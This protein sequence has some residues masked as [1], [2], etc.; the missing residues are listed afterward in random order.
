MIR[1]FLVLTVLASCGGAATTTPLDPVDPGSPTPPAPRVKFDPVPQEIEAS[2]P[3]V[4]LPAVPAFDLPEAEPGFRSVKELRVAGRKLLGT[5]VKVKG[6]VAWVYNCADA[7]VAGGVPAATVKQTIDADPT[8]CERPNF[9]LAADQGD[10]ATATL[11]VVEVPRAPNKLEKQRLP[12]EDLKAWPRVPVIRVGDHV[13]VTG[14]WDTRSPHGTAS[15]DGLIVY[16]D[17]ASVGGA[18]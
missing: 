14:T 10:D 1:S 3:A 6:Y 15:T 12:K 13:V 16:G 9:Y 18:K 4:A 11:W 17:V 8:L 5:T 7:L 2:P